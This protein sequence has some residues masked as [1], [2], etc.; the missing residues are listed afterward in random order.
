MRKTD[1][2]SIYLQDTVPFKDNYL[3][4]EVYESNPTGRTDSLE[5]YLTIPSEDN[6]SRIC[7]HIKVKFNDNNNG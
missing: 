5:I 3:T 7:K 6:K 4:V 2:R 1:A